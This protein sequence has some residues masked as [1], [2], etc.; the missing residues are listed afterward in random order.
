[1]GPMMRAM[2]DRRL[3]QLLALMDIF[4]S[5]QENANPELSSLKTMGVVSNPCP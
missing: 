4:A 5:S 3:L 2:W 1:M